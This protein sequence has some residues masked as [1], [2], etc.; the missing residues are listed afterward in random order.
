VS[1]GRKVKQ[2]PAASS[3]QLSLMGAASVRIRDQNDEVCSLV[4][5]PGHQFWAKPSHCERQSRDE[6]PTGKAAQLTD[7]F[8]NRTN[9]K[10]Q[11]KSAARL[12]IRMDPIF[13][14]KK[15]ESFYPGEMIF[16]LTV[17]AGSLGFACPAPFRWKQTPRVQYDQ[18]NT[19]LVAWAEARVFPPQLIA[20]GNRRMN[21]ERPISEL[22]RRICA[23]FV[24]SAQAYT[25]VFVAAAGSPRRWKKI[26][27][28]GI[29]VD[30]LT[31]LDYSDNYMMQ[32][33]KGIQSST[34]LHR[35]SPTPLASL[36]T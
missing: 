4:R 12:E 27:T 24:I 33:P 13:G 14:Q 23:W 17:Q 16:N 36:L 15:S 29:I 22:R 26:F 2:A 10:S 31:F 19:S 8:I 1:S 25:A 18:N 7:I 5:Q 11:G 30:N 9:G 21:P 32:G 34:T 6:N 35:I 3:E 20:P 28:I